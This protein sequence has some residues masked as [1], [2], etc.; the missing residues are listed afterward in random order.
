M[1]FA[2][3]ET[4]PNQEAIES[5][6]WKRAQEKAEK[7]GKELTDHMAGVK[8]AFGQVLCIVATVKVGGEWFTFDKI[9]K[10]E[11]LL[12]AEFIVWLNK[13]PNDLHIFIAHNGKDFDLPFL[14]IRILANGLMLPDCLK[15]AG[16]KPWEINHIDTMELVK[17]GGWGNSM[18][19]DALCLV[20]GVETPKDGIDGSEV[21][22]AFKE[23]RL[24]EILDYCR[25]DV[26]ALYKCYQR[27]LTLKAI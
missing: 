8:P 22:E 18:S 7:S 23:G 12:L 25:K 2:D 24:A 4:I 21:W 16:K 27:L 17:F 11:K 14:A 20:L 5:P 3:I 9:D 10:N 26:S 13:L 6:A 19:L 15:V 1:I